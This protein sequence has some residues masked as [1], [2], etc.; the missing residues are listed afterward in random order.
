MP[1]KNPFQTPAAQSRRGGPVKE[2]LTRERIVDEAL[3]V[4]ER[5]GVAGVSLRRIA[6]ALDTGPASLYPYVGD[7]DGLRALVL[8]AALSAVDVR[9]SPRRGWRERLKAVMQSYL[10]VLLQRPGLARL[11]TP[12]PAVGPQLLRIL[13]AILALLEEGGVDR[14][15]AAWAV[16]LLLL[17]VTGIA[18]EQCQGHDPV[19]RGGPVADAIAAAPGSDYP[20]VAA[21]RAE[22]LAGEGSERFSWAVDV[23]LAGIAHTAVQ[24]IPTRA[25][26]ARPGAR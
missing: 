15:T 19:G 18:L 7:F 24:S 25:N 23:L 21:A 26:A 9:G 16:D 14:A 17:Y 20:H 6:A 8:D 4:L 2:P 22:L 13:D 11:A 1:S 10:S 5:E 3:A 12:T